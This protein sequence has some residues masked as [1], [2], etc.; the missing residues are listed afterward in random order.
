M[1]KNTI[2]LLL[3]ICIKSFSQSTSVFDANYFNSDNTEPSLR[4]G[5]GFHINDIYKQTKNCFKIETINPKNLTSQQVG[6]KK[7]NYKIF[8]TKNTKEFNDYKSKGN[9]G[10]VS[11]LNL[12]ELEGKKLEEF[13]SNSAVE[14]ERLIF[15]ANVDFGIFSFAKEPILN[16]ESKN[17]IT[18]NKLQ[19]FVNL[20]GTHFISGIRKES[21]IT[22]ILKKSSSRNEN[23]YNSDS[24][25]KSNG[26]VPTKGKGAFEIINND[27]VNKEINQNSFTVT[28]E[29][30]GPSLDENSIQNSINSILESN[31]QNKANAISEIISGAIKNISNSN[32][33]II[34]Q[35]YYSPYSLYG[36]AGINWDSKKQKELTKLNEI[37]ISIY[38]GKTI[39]KYY[40][41][42]ANLT[43]IKNHIDNSNANPALFEEIKN[44]FLISSN[45]LKQLNNEIDIEIENIEK[46][47]ISCSDVFCLQLQDCCNNS[48][49]INEMNLK[50]Y[51][52]KIITEIKNYSEYVNNIL[53]E[54]DKPECE[55]K[56]LGKITIQNL[57]TNPYDLYGGNKY[58][59]IIDGGK[60]L[61]YYV[62][63]GQY[64]F[65][66]IQRSGFVM[67]PTENVRNTTITQVCQEETL[68]IG[69]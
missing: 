29:V 1:K 6:G 64:S 43:G 38:S 15:T 36:L 62:G 30:N 52:N 26:T 11:F 51:E 9:S 5:K 69:Y 27:W 63:N 40:L 67:Y 66:A 44:K 17:L 59:G 13:S 2:L 28:V 25:I 50:N 12:F 24:T 65:K 20:F 47:Y 18:Q 48:A 32:Q 42:N 7:T 45:N 54:I 60:M 8:Y 41:E 56:Q 23:E 14:E 61:T 68:K 3:F 35:Y 21:N 55:K 49:Y 10:S 58:L 46:K 57:S 53:N 37:L 16:D 31:S 39:S 22:V 33:S 4:I 19:N 34:T